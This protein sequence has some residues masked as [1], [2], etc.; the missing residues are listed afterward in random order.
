VDARLQIQAWRLPA[1]TAVVERL[2]AESP[3]DEAATLLLGRIRLLEKNYDEAMRLGLQIQ[4]AS[5]RNPGGYLLEADARFWKEDP[6][7]A[8]DPLVRALTLA[9][10]DPDARFNYGYA[11]WRRVDATQLEAMAGNWNL[12]LAVDPL[13]YVTHWHYGNGHT[14]FTYADYAERSDTTVRV[15]LAQ[16]DSLISGGRIAEAL[17]VAR[18]VE[19]EHPTSVLPAMLRASALYMAH[20]VERSMRLDSAQAIFSSILER[21]W[22]YGPAHNGLAAVIK[23]RQFTFLASYD[24]LQA[25]IA[26]TP[27]P[28]DPALAYVF[29]DLRYYPGERVEKMVRQQLGPSM[30]YLPLIQRQERQY[31]IPPL[32]RD[33]AAAMGNPYFRTATTFDNRQWM[34]IRGVGSGAAAIEYVERGSHQERDVLL[35]EFV[36]LFH[37]NVFTDAENRRV[38]ELYNAAMRENRTLDYYAANNESEFLGQAYP[39]FLSPVKIHPLKHKATAVHDDLLRKDPATYAFIDSLVARQRAALAGDPTVLRSNWA[40]VYLNL[41][42]AARTDE[43]M[44]PPERVRTATALLDSALVWDDRYLPAL[45]SYAALHREERRW[46]EAER[47]LERAEAVDRRYAPIYAARAELVG[48]RATTE[49]GLT[50]STLDRQ[51]ELYRTAL[52]LER[53]LTIR[54]QLNQTLRELYLAHGRLEDALRV[55]EEYVMA[56]PTVSTYLRDRRDEAAAFAHQLRATAGYSEESVAFFRELVAQKPQN[57]ALRA[58]L[59]DA[60]LQAGRLD[61]ARESVEQVQRILEAG[62]TANAALITRLAEIRLL[63]GDTLGAEAVLTPI[64]MARV[65]PERGD[66]RLI[67]IFVAIGQTTEAQLRLAELPQ[68]VTPREVAELAL[69]RGRLLGRRGDRSQAERFYREAIAADAYNREARLALIRLLTGSGRA[70]EAALVVDAGQSLPLPLGPDFQREAEHVG[71]GR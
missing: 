52:D 31:R 43:R 6:A 4:S 60:L 2:L 68:P 22:N 40:Q 47:W 61:E 56:A 9:P 53:D 21:K 12:A 10:F 15:L 55:A 45:L 28:Y 58:Q 62:G 18:Q 38:R 19:R 7:G 11:L 65:Q 54:A 63:Q 32:H 36:H 44:A 41:S 33:L 1:A 64:L 49:A 17:T 51:V 35:H 59:V 8:E 34:D 66:H 42:Q 14:N 70:D 48:A 69:T 20:D 30:A 3:R 16:A 37:G 46:E 25:A 67:R 5:P 26:A 29:P 23:Q 57:Y 27:T 50:G 71:A 24:S 39:A 13:H